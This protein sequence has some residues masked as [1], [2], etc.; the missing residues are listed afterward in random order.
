VTITYSLGPLI[1][2]RGRTPVKTE[3]LELDLFSQI[4]QNGIVFAFQVQ[5]SLSRDDRSNESPQLDGYAVTN[6][7]TKPFINPGKENQGNPVCSARL[8]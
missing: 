7:L 5:S 1:L 6:Y 3:S 8:S 4:F 2:S